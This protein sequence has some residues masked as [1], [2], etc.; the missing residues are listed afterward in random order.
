MCKIGFDAK[1]GRCRFPSH[2]KEYLKNARKKFPSCQWA[3]IK[4]R[5]YLPNKEQFIRRAKESYLRRKNDV[6]KR[7][8]DWRRFRRLE[9]ILRFGGRCVRCAY[10]RHPEILQFHHRNGYG[11]NEMTLWPALKS[12]SKFELLCPDCHLIETLSRSAKKKLTLDDIR[13]HDKRDEMLKVFGGKCFECGS[14]DKRLL[15]FDHINPRFKT[16]HRKNT[17]N[18]M[19]AKRHPERFQL[20]CANCHWLK[21]LKEAGCVPFY[22]FLLGRTKKLRNG[23]AWLKIYRDRLASR[24]EKVS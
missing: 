6:I 24:L 23:G 10:S 12:P 19:E 15:N 13:R 7:T 5:Q 16:G 1:L 22:D 21:T 9:A 8:A 17:R 2:Q 18:E 20:L 4:K 11:R 3:Y 14:N